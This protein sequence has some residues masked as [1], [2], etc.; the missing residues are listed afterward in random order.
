M[1]RLEIRDDELEVEVLGLHKL[2]ALR[3]RI[4]VPLSAVATVR[5][6]EADQAHGWWKGL[7]M[8]GT[9]VPG[10]IVAGTFYKDGERHFWDVRNAHRAIEVQLSGG[11][12]DRLFV[13]VEDPDQA[14]RTLVGARGA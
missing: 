11:P 3:G 6:L 13:E 10:L 4:R 1:V 8:P 7:R 12:F 5:R 9:H 14:I 2:W